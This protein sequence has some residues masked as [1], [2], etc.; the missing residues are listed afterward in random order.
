MHRFA[1]PLLLLLAA[2]AAAADD[3]ALPPL[4]ATGP[5]PDPA[6]VAADAAGVT[7]EGYPDAD[8]VLVD[9][10]VREAYRPD[11]T[12]ESLDDEYT[13]ILTEKGRRENAVRS[14]FFLAAY[15]TVTVSR[16]EIVKPDGRRVAV[17][18]AANSR[19]A[20]DAGQM[21]ANIFDPNM[22]FLQLSV[23]GLEVGDLLH[24][25]AI[26]TRHK[27]HVPDTWADGTPLE[28]DMP[29]RRFTYEVLSPAARPLRHV[30]L[31]APV[32]N[33][34]TA[35]TATLPDG[36]TLRRWVARDVPQV[37]PEP[38]MPPLD[39]VVQRVVLSTAADWP[40]ISRWYW[41]LCRP[42]L[43][44]VTPAMHATVSNLVA[45]AAGRAERLRR[46]F[47]FV[48]QQVR[49][50]GITVEAVAPGYEPHDVC[51]TF[52]SR[53]GVCR[54]KAALLVAMLRLAGLDAFPVLINVGGK[55][56]AEAPLPWF[57][58]AIVGVA[59]PDG[60]YDLMDP[61][62]ESTR[63]PFPSYLG[64]RS[65]LVASPAGDPLRVSDVAPAARN[66]VRIASRGS[67]GDDGALSLDATLAFDGINDTA[68]RGRFLRQKP[69]ERRRFFEGLLKAR[70]PGAEIGAFRLTPDDLLDTTQPLA[71]A[72]SARVPDAPV[73]GDGASLLAL[74]WLGPGVGLVN[75]LLDGATLRQRRYPYVSEL[76][77]GVEETIAIGLGPGRGAPRQLPAAARFAR[78]GTEFE[79]QAAV[80]NNTLHARYRHLL[81]QPEYSPAEYADLKQ[82]LRDIEY[83][84]RQRV[85]FAGPPAAPQA[86]ARVLADDLV[87]ELA[88]A[89]EWTAT[90]T[91]VRQ[92]LTYNGRKRNA[93]IKMPFNPAWQ[94]AELVE[95]TVSN[96]DGRVRTVAPEAIN[97]MDQEWVGA[98][99]RYPAGRVR[100]VTL[101]GV[102]TGS[103]IRFV[104]RR[105][106][107]DAPF[108]SLEQ[109]FGGFDPVARASLEVIAP[110]GLALAADTRHGELLRATCRTNGAAVVRRWEAGPLPAA[111]AEEHLPPWFAWRPAVLLSAGDWARYSRDV[112]RAFERALDDDRAARRRGRELARGLRDPLAR[113]AAVRNDLA[114]AVREAGPGFTDL[115][116]ACL[117]GA[118]RTLAEGYGH[119]ADRAIL[120]TAMLRAA[121]LDA[122][123][124]LV[125]AAPR[126]P[127]ALFDPLFA[128]PQPGL[129]GDVLVEV[130]IGGRTLYLND[131]GQYD[132]PGA[133]GHD[134]HP[135]LALDGGTGRIAVE[136]GRRDRRVAEWTLDLA[137]DGRAAIAV[138]NRYF[139]MACG[140][141][142]QQTL[143]MP[144]E[145]R[146]RFFQ[147]LVAQ[148]SQSAKPVGGLVTQTDAY[149]PWRAFAVE[150]ERYAVAD[151]RTLT[152]L[153]PGA[154]EPLLPLRADRRTGPLQVAEAQASAWRCRVILPPGATG[155]PVRPQA[156]DWPLPEG[157]GRVRLE[158][159]CGRQADGRLTVDFLR[160]TTLEPALLDADLYPAL[161]EINRRLTHPQMR[162]V[163]VEMQ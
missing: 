157:L 118:D 144:P 5:L 40:T 66:L 52:D 19:V 36:R 85:V 59:R 42:R 121:G 3:L 100:A 107:R 77:C 143:E 35:T 88:S 96:L 41:E 46:L 90:R 122:D 152:V 108:F 128:A 26:R 124:V 138:T 32:S 54:D 64:N 127:A 87:V 102:E 148:V 70:L 20:I 15:G 14:F 147:A 120:L 50:A 31:R 39:T 129:F 47:T 103:V 2:A 38:G 49:Y 58:H 126:L 56:D 114:T 33:R 163:L 106:Q 82:C 156:F 86:D 57:N 51:L 24:L 83:A 134:R 145:E 139:G 7:A 94:T 92:V 91:V 79:L 62:N 25:T 60:G 99:G 111:Q 160:T 141:F 63:D 55:L 17:D 18:P 80:S 12:A 153:L 98:A 73:A 1:L 78:S 84:G 97:L 119:G 67:L 105:T 65:Y 74:P 142:R 75:T 123:P 140:E 155:L 4:L 109:N 116:L 161:L 34:V 89:R 136:P 72:L 104:V 130:E 158:V 132:E 68:Y 69:E 10:L 150:A 135:F 44:A 61:T 16:V 101:P 115:P 71:A 125:S 162:T 9:D 95:A 28:G 45:G 11:G 43:D 30:L 76:A 137:A 110:R 23:P 8:T 159:E 29:V 146:D 21:G 13:K 22:K 154:A 133:T 27:S 117:G 93:E 37:F 113:L 53:S 6:A 131:T 48:S 112:R 151:A 81:L 149:P